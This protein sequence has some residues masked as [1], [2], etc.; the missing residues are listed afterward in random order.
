MN[1]RP[2]R[3]S[4]LPPALRHV[5]ELEIV[6]HRRVPLE[7]PDREQ[8]DVPERPEQDPVAPVAPDKIIGAK[9]G[10]MCG[11]KIRESVLAVYEKV[12]RWK[13]NLFYLPTGKAGETFIEELARVINLFNSGSAF[14]SVS[15]MMA[16][17][18]FPLLLQKPSPHSKASDHVK[19]LE[20]RLHLWK[21]GNLEDLLSEGV[22]IQNRL[23]RTKRQPDNGEQ[24]FVRLMEDGKISA[25]LR[26]IG[27]LQC[28]VHDRVKYISSI[29]TEYKIKA[30]AVFFFVFRAQLLFFFF[31]FGRC[32]LKPFFIPHW[33][34][35]YLIE[36]KNYTT[37]TK[38]Q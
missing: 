14:E 35:A 34:K 32:N 38:K 31:F 15:L 28:G 36:A 4:V 1:D 16:T 26:C 2:R 24:R 25:A 17:V 12:T 19:Y 21:E 23:T 7:E 6:N 9:W 22:A 33:Y 13:R 8:D 37:H 18:I 5:F 20:K 30:P 3:I 27:S 11:T 29:N 10:E